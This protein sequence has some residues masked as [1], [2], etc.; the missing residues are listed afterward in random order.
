MK[1]ALC[2]VIERAID[3]GVVTFISGGAIGVDLWAAEA[4]IDARELGR[5][6]WGPGE[7]L[8]RLIVAQPFPSQDCKWPY[9]SRM[10]YQEIMKQADKVIAVC[11]DPYAAWKMQK[12]N[13]WMVDHADM[14]L[15]V[16]DGSPGGTGN[17]VNYALKQNHNGS[18]PVLVID[19]LRKGEKWI[20]GKAIDSETGQ[21]VDADGIDKS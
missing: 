21:I 11:D 17:T 8:P 9:V 7:T 20:N 6:L 19:P 15:A 1:A 4:V 18:K 10:E 5:E 2:G 16:W 3:A 12:R 14:V 13:E